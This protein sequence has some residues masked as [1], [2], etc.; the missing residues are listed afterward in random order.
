MYDTFE[1]MTQPEKQDVG[2]DGNDL[3]KMWER[4]TAQ[5]E[6]PW[7]GYGGT[8]EEVRDTVYASNYPKDNFV[9]VKGPVEDIVPDTVPEKIALL[10][11]DT[12]WYSS[13]YH[14][15]V[16][17]YPLIGAGGILIIDDYGWCRGARQATDQYI[18]ENKL[19]LFL[20]RVDESVRLAIK[21]I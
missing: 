17:L 18:K 2:W 16:H 14:E 1:G 8:I 9:F 3:R 15:L 20:N 13:T 10:R 5:K 4:D 7:W 12:D 6:N 21:R 19:D 11:L